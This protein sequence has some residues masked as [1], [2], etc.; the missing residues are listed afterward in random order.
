MS[1]LLWCIRESLGKL[2]PDGFTTYL[3]STSFSSIPRT[4][5]KGVASSIAFLILRTTSSDAFS[6]A[7]KYQNKIKCEIF[8]RFTNPLIP[9]TIGIEGPQNTGKLNSS[10]FKDMVNHFPSQITQWQQHCLNSKNPLFPKSIFA[11]LSN[12]ES[13]ITF[14]ERRWKFPNDIRTFRTAVVFCLKERFGRSRIDRVKASKILE[15]NNKKS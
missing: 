14:N 2:S 7:A 9:K 5:C 15:P 1:P 3:L 12:E 11:S 6:K 13:A 10:S 8:S 4:S